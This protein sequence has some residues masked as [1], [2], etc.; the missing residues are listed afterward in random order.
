EEKVDAYSRTAVAAL[1]ARPELTF[2]LYARDSSALESFQKIALRATG[3]E[4]SVAWD[5]SGEPLAKTFSKPDDSPVIPGFYAF[6]D[7]AAIADATVVL[8]DSSG[9]VQEIRFWSALTD[10]G[11]S[12]YATVPIFSSLDPTRPGLT[13]EDFRRSY[14]GATH[15]GSR[16]VIGYLSLG[17]PAAGWARTAVLS[18][19]PMITALL[20]PL[21]GLL[22][23]SLGLRRRLAAPMEELHNFSQQ[24]GSD[25][26]SATLNVQA[27]GELRDVFDA[28]SQLLLRLRRREQEVEAAQKMLTQKADESASTL[29]LREQELKQA[30]EEISAAKDRLHR[31]SYY[32]SLT[33]LPNRVLFNEQFR[34]L[35]S[36][37]E[38]DGRY[39]A[40]VLVNLNNFRRINESLGHSIGDQILALVAQRL[41][42]CVRA[43][44]VLATRPDGAASEPG[45]A[46]IG[47]D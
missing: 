45:V 4:S 44:D 24:I 18:A 21:L 29:S 39:L 15:N 6:R 32:D 40:L 16:V 42:G 27:G 20:I 41:I 23:I 37:R 2:L 17:S 11:S 8:T 30:T 35:L 9:G 13:Q 33:S 12:I 26:A 5:A 36:V 22:F 10:S 7:D 47:G 34:K 1:S 28:L 14:A 43:S 31:A 3:S 25:G 38:R 19:W 46:R